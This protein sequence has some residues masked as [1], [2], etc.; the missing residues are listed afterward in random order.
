M[1]EPGKV[2][3]WNLLGS[4]EAGLWPQVPGATSSKQRMQLLTSYSLSQAR[5]PHCTQHVEL[6]DKGA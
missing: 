6:W 1:V 2:P 4:G 3:F 5:F